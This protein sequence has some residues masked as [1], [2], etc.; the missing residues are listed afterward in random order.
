MP[1]GRLQSFEEAGEDLLT[2]F[3]LNVPN[4]LHVSLLSTNCIENAFKNLR[5]HIGRVC[6]WRHETKQADLW[7]SSGLALA[8]KGFRRIR[9]YQDIPKLIEALEK[10]MRKQKEDAT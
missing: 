10:S 8:A 7:V 9:G 1:T 6:R 3:R 5:R 4:T 2:L